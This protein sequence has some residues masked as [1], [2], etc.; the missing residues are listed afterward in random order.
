[1]DGTM[2]A[3][4]WMLS[5]T[6]RGCSDLMGA[7]QTPN[8][9]SLRKR[10]QELWFIRTMEYSSTV[11]RKEILIFTATWMNP[12]NMALSDNPVVKGQND[13]IPLNA[14]S[15]ADSAHTDR[16]SV[17]SHGPGKVEVHAHSFG[18]RCQEKWVREN[19]YFTTSFFHWVPRPIP[20]APLN[21]T[22]NN[23]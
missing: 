9:S 8:T 1:M 3:F 19:K 5:A 18:R 12:E 11:K 10:V 14:R 7:P 2:D 16:T 17:G 13:L 4:G 22:K 23:P 6:E 15:L 20:R 21:G